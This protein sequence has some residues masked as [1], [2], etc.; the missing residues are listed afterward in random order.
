MNLLTES[1]IRA[2]AIREFPRECCGLVVQ[3]N[4]SELYRPCRNVAVTAGEHFVIH[5]EDRADAEDAGEIVGVVHSHPQVSARPSEA[6]QVS[7]EQTGL[8]WHIV[9]VSRNPD[10]KQIVTGELYSF[11]PSGYIAP[12]RGRTF[13][14]GVLDCYTLI[15][16]YYKRELGVELPDFERRDDWWLHG[17]NLYMDNFAKAGFA[18]ITGRMQPGDVIIMQIRAKVA[19]HAGIYMG[20]GHI[21]HHYAGRLSALDVYD[22]YWQRAT[23]VV[24]RRNPDATV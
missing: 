8:E 9:H 16:D 18:P 4:G 2:H 17:E 22:G 7:C 23:R 12:L 24:V 3:V 11:K 5:H 6:D 14:H 1:E 13:A 19:N 10:T 21:L 20:D 15:R